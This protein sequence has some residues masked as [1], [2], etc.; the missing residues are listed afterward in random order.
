MTSKIVRLNINLSTTYFSSSSVAFYHP[1][2][3][4]SDT[5]LDFTLKCAKTHRGLFQFLSKEDYLSPL[6]HRHILCFLSVTWVW[7]SIDLAYIFVSI[8]NMK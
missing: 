8:R 1:C 6:T 7:W 4:N 2:T 3:R 5:Y